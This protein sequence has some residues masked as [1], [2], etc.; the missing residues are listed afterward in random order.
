APRLRD[1]N[2]DGLATSDLGAYEAGRSVPG[3]GP[4]NGFTFQ[5]KTTLVWSAE[6]SAATYTILRGAGGS[7]NS[8][9]GYCLPATPLQSGTAATTLPETASPPVGAF[10]YSLV[11][12][13]ASLNRPGT[14]GDGT[15]A[16]I[17]RADLCPGP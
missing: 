3:P 13:V 2:G 5:N 8:P 14:L 16:E 11:Q 17:S 10:F 6:P 7:G 1:A 9:L 15:C 4:V 12:A